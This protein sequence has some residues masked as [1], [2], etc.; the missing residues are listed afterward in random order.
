MRGLW[1]WVV[2]RLWWGVERLTLKAWGKPRL[3]TWLSI[4][5]WELDKARF[6][7]ERD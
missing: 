4:L 3:Y 7:F 6:W 5:S 1:Y 2:S